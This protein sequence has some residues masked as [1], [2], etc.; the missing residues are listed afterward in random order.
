MEQHQETQAA[1]VGRTSLI[2]PL[3]IRTNYGS[4]LVVTVLKKVS[5]ETLAAF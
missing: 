4:L 1:G 5:Y 2:N 3:Q